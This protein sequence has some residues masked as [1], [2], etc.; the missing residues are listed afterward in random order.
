[1]YAREMRHGL[2]FRHTHATTLGLVLISAFAGFNIDRESDFAW[3][4]G[5]C[6]FG[7]GALICVFIPVFF[8]SLFTKESALGNLDMLLMTSLSPQEIARG[9]MYAAAS[10]VGTL[11]LISL[12]ANTVMF[13]LLAPRLKAGFVLAVMTGQI[14]ICV[15]AALVLVATMWASILSKRSGAAIITSF[16][17]SFLSLFGAITLIVILSITSRVSP[18]D[19]LIYLSPVSAC[20]VIMEGLVR[21]PDD[22]S[23]AGWIV[24]MAMHTL[25][26]YAL[27]IGAIRC[28]ASRVST[29]RFHY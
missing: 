15:C 17:L 4:W 10:R 2:L 20:G 26:V 23:L 19:S 1:M 22:T 11:L 16:A 21:R 7:H 13:L 14:T 12:A 27:Y 3:M 8:S 9:K 28:Y 5:L 25:A 18:D 29:K 6:C 24:S